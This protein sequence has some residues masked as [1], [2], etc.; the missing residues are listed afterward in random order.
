MAETTATTATTEPTPEELK[1]QDHASFSNVRGVDCFDGFPKG[2]RAAISFTGGKD[3]HLAL[4]RANEGGLDVVCAAVFSAPGKEFQAHRI[5]WQTQQAEAAIGIP[6]AMC[7][8]T[9]LEN[10][11][12]DYKAAYAAAIRKLQEEYKIEVIVTG[13]ID[14][15]FTSTTNFMQ[16]V[17]R[18]YDSNGVQVVLPLFQQKRE[19]LLMEMLEKHDFDIRYCCVKTPHFDESWIGRR[20]DAQAID[21]MKVKHKDGLD[22]TGEN[23]EY[24]TMVVNAPMYGTPLDFVGVQVKELLAQRGQKNVERWWVIHESTQLKPRA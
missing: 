9:E 5:E 19:D 18:N 16:E 3:C 7:S 24:H 14:Y 1:A 22:L 17:C 20:L 21:E 15:V 8:L 4:Q 10:V 11:P 12:G 2:T 13:D 23:G 6:L